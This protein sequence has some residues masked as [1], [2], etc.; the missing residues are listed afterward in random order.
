MRKWMAILMFMMV[1]SGCSA[2]TDLETVQYD[3]QESFPVYQPG[4]M[5]LILP[6][7]VDME[8]SSTDSGG[9]FYSFGN[10]KIWMESHPTGNINATLEL[11]TGQSGEKR[12]LVKWESEEYRYYETVWTTAEESGIRVNRGVVA[13]DGKYHY[14]IAVSV[15]EAEADHAD[16]IVTMILDGLVISVTV[17]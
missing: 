1:L 15:P 6:E 11:L 14:C 9:I 17:Q 10:C 8:S 16:Q 2:D 5:N 4:E 12:N 13:D 3:L 7:S